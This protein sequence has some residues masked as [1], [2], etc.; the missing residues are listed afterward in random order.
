MMYFIIASIVINYIVTF[1][2][3]RDEYNRGL[4][5]TLSDLIWGSLFSLVPL[6]YNCNISFSFV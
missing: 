4:D 3:L 2:I 6:F 1:F 5:I